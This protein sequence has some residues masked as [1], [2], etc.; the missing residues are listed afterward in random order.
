MRFNFSA[1]PIPS[2]V[3]TTSTTSRRRIVAFDGV[4]RAIIEDNVIDTQGR[5]WGIE[6]YADSNSIVRHNTLLYRANCDYNTACGTI[7]LD[8]KSSDPA[9]R[10]TIIVDNIATS[11][12]DR[13]WLN[14]CGAAS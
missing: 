6:L 11:I 2:S 12:V 1:L 8:H 13:Q 10:G 4:A 5:P 14:L 9:G 3:A 7:A